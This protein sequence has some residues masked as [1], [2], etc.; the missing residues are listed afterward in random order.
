MLLEI[1]CIALHWFAVY[2]VAPE[3]VIKLGCVCSV[4]GIARQ[5]KNEH[6]YV[7]HTAPEI[8][9]GHPF[10]ISADM[11]SVGV[12]LWEVWHCMQANWCGNQM[13][14]VELAEKIRLGTVLPLMESCAGE[15]SVA[16]WVTVWE[17][18]WLAVAENRPTALSVYDALNQLK[19]DTGC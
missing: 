8:L 1:N 2:Q 4:R 10:S 18:C 19:L 5:A 16:A 15:G 12:L 14:E 3:L 9:L 13:D 6:G 17:N 7:M 11:F